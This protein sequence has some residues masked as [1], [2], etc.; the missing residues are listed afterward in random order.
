MTNTETVLLKLVAKAINNNYL[1]DL[2]SYC[3]IDWEEMFHLAT[4]QG[5]AGLVMD[6]ISTLP[7]ENRPIGAVLFNWIGYGCRMENLYQYHRKAIIQLAEF[8]AQNGYQM[9]LL[10]GYGLSRCWPVPQH[11]PVGDIDIYLGRKNNNPVFGQRNVWKEADL[12]I[13]DKLG[14]NIDNS[15][16][17]HSVFPY[18]GISV[19]NHF[20]FINAYDHR[21]SRDM[22]SIF[23]QMAADNYVRSDESK[24]LYFP[25]DD[26]NALFILK[27]CSGHFASTEITIRHLLD[28][29]LFIRYHHDTIHWDS[30]Y[31]QY[32]R[33]GL[34]RLANIFSSIGFNYL[35]MDKSLFYNLEGDNNLVDRVLNDILSPEFSEHENGTLLSGLWVKPRRFWHNRWKHKIC[36]T[37]SFISGF[38][39]TTYAKML[40]PRH[41]KV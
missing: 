36:Y 38:L 31:T 14:I 24:D 2:S 22:E 18:K 41:F 19:E 37:D 28:W 10:K 16:H 29:L 13:H 12:V 3:P 20:D 4:A 17:H 32:E 40:K 27:H 35:G 6:T 15:H 30:L 5:V 39:W 23:K 33:F 21:S 34:V 11:R 9:M 7:K 26:F 8:Y 1:L 25:S